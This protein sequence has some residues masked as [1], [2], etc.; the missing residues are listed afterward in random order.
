MIAG[1]VAQAGDDVNVV[2]LGQA[3]EGPHR[4]VHAA[5]RV[6]ELGGLG[7]VA[8]AEQ[9]RGLRDQ[10]LGYVADEFLERGILPAEGRAS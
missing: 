4:G 7:M 1:R 9:S 5:G 2:R 6:E 8:L 3:D 10:D